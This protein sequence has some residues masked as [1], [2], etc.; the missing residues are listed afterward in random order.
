MRVNVVIPV[1]VSRRRCAL[2]LRSS[3]RKE[4]KDWIDEGSPSE[5]TLGERHVAQSG[6]PPSGHP[7]IEECCE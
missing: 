3:R 4:T 1:K 5:Y 2:L 7:I 6:L